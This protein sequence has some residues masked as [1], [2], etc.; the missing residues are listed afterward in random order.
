[1]SPLRLCPGR[2][3][4]RAR[5]VRRGPTTAASAVVDDTTEPATDR[6]REPALALASALAPASTRGR[7]TAPRTS[8]RTVP[9]AVGFADLCGFTPL[10]RSL[11]HD[12]LADLLDRF[13][14]AAT[15]V[16]PAC[17]AT[18]VKLLGDGVLFHAPHPRVAV[19][20]A[21][22]LVDETRADGRLPATRAAVA[23]GRVLLRG[24]DCFGEVVNR[25]SRL[26]EVAPF[27][28]VAVDA[29]ALD[30]S[31][32]WRS[33]GHHNLRDYGPWPVWVAVS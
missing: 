32:R 3:D 18:V 11:D 7:S 10:A 2:A 16:L 1:M 33:L 26:L 24:G 9:L 25:A 12:E 27:E 6:L 5:S 15:L 30:E 14:T 28:A 19:D 22:A 29:S 23:A 4:A 20:A 17:G 21:L 31:R 8:I 13:E